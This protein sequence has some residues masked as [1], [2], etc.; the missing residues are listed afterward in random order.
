LIEAGD[1]RLAASVAHCCAEFRALGCAS[2]HTFNP[3]PIHRCYYRLC[4]DCARERQRRACGRLFP[5]LRGFQRAYPHDRQVLITLTVRSS[6]EALAVHDRR[7]KA[8][9]KRLRRSKR[10]KHCIR[11]AVASFEFTWNEAEG[12][13]Y[14]AHILAFRRAWYAQDELAEQWQRITAG[15]G[16]VVDIREAH[17]FRGAVAEVV[18]YCFKPAEVETWTVQQVAEFNALRR[19]KL[20]DCYGELRGLKVESDDDILPEIERQHLEIGSPCPDCGQP[21]GVVTVPRASSLW[22]FCPPPPL[23]DILSFRRGAAAENFLV[24][25]SAHYEQRRLKIT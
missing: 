5:I 11:G 21:L 3:I 20:S 16:V 6:H 22:T 18:K 4:V 15:A 13:H 1:Y 8:W 17:D 14:H 9:F 24:F 19:T 25:L 23:K 12:W 10:W 2:G 7:F